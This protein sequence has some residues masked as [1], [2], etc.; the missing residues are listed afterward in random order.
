M[1]CGRATDTA[2]LRKHR[3]LIILLVMAALV[4]V[5]L[6]FIIPPS[7][8]T[9]LG[10]DLQGGLEIVYTAKTADGKAPSVAQVD[11]TIGILDRRV[12]GLGVTESQ[13]QKQGA[14]QVSVSL[15]G[16]KDAQQA[17][18]IIG[19]TAQLQFF[20]DDPRSRPV[21]PWQA[22]NEALKELEQLRACQQGRDRPAGRRGHHRA[23]TPWSRSRRARAATTSAQWAVYRLPPAMTGDAISKARAGFDGQGGKPARHHRLHQRRQQARSRRSRGSS[24]APALLKQARRRRSPSCSTTSW[25]RTR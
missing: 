17:L 12:N 20:K 10:L 24:T 13:I 8:K 5:S 15:P 19:K 11:Q 3:N 21:G 23:S 25:S 14:D 18:D 16:V 2:E 4:A 9:H 1:A 7:V 6:Y 22:R